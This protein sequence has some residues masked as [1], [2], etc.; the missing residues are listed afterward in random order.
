MPNIDQ[1]LKLCSDLGIDASHYEDAD[2]PSET[3]HVWEVG[4]ES[5]DNLGDLPDRLSHAGEYEWIG[6]PQLDGPKWLWD[7]RERHTVPANESN[8]AEG[9]VAV[10]YTWGRW[11]LEDQM[12]VRSGTSWPVP[13]I[14]PERTDF[15]F[16]GLKDVLSKIT[17]CRYFW[18]D[19]FC[20]NQ[21]DSAERRAEIA[22]IGSIF[23]KAKGVLTYLWGLQSG[24][25]LAHALCDLGDMILWMLR[26]SAPRD[27]ECSKYAKKQ[28]PPEF[29]SL[30]RSDPWFE[31][32]WTL[33]EM[34]LCPSTLWLARNGDF[35]T[36]NSRK[37]TT[38]LVASA[39]TLFHDVL[40]LRAKF[41]ET[42]LLKVEKTVETEDS[43]ISLGDAKWLHKRTT[44]GTKIVEAI[45]SWLFWAERRACIISSLAASRT[46]ILVAAAKRVSVG[47][48]TE[49][50]L[51]ALK[52]ASFDGIS[53]E[54]N[55]ITGS[56]PV[57]LLNA[58]LEDD[59]RKMFDV[60]HNTPVID[61]RLKLRHFFS[62]ITPT[63]AERCLSNYSRG[64]QSVLHEGWRFRDDGSLYI[65]HGSIIQAFEPSDDA[66][67]YIS[68]H[69]VESIECKASAAESAVRSEYIKWRNKL[70]RAS[71]RKKY[72]RKI[73]VLFCPVAIQDVAMF[74]TKGIVLVTNAEVIEDDSPLHWYK[75]G[76]YRVFIDKFYEMNCP[77]GIVVGSYGS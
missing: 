26:F 12:E 32:L 29:G 64:F 27:R 70:K 44:E 68:L 16:D 11:R 50:V 55:H 73:A 49:A 21:H 17:C 72:P 67:I 43:V 33:Q 52:I 60:D 25:E 3:R 75:C 40:P 31:S 8:L 57:G 39:C 2:T 37:V 47:Q 59:G 14:D 24:D 74:N 56:F 41:V 35:C 36:I 77:R 7:A 45:T 15:T 71:E 69:S 46:A 28:S 10:S 9:Y 61:A 1:A 38:A 6:E 13:M 5:I 18:I 65:P 20:I 42:M 19:V 63:T 23:A 66:I 51:A 76:T 22:K 34:I 54:E 30:L 4:V 48:R 58:V 53:D 62:E